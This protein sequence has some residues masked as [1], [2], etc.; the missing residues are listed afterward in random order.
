MTIIKQKSVSSERHAKNVRDYLDGKD[1][2]LRGGW[3][4]F[5]TPDWF[6]RMASTRRTFGHDKPARAGAKNTILYHQVLAFLP[7]ESSCNG[8]P[9]TP[10]KCMLYAEQ[11]ISERYPNHQVVYVLHEE[12]DEQGKRFAV[13]LAIN[14]S[15]VV[16]GKRLDEGRSDRAKRARAAHVRRLDEEWGL[17]QVKKGVP[18][19]KIR[20]Q[21]PRGAEAAML[22]RGVKPYKFNMRKLCQLARD[23][24]ESMEEFLGMLNEWGV[25]VKVENGRLYTADADDPNP[26]KF[27]FNLARLDNSFNADDLASAY[28][29]FDVAVGAVVERQNKEEVDA[30]RAE[31]LLKVLREF[32]AYEKTAE[33]AKG[34]PYDEFPKFK[35]PKQPACIFKDPETQRTVMD[36]IIRTEKLKRAMAANT[37]RRTEL[38]GRP[39]RRSQDAQAQQ[40]RREADRAPER[41][42]ERER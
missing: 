37:P 34:T 11:W 7:E 15:D 4:I 39:G 18:N 28:P 21:K 13:H 17:Q 41:T 27:W 5:Y 22:A 20:V 8:G 33:E 12:S 10:E 29:D 19:S 31:Y 23:N 38:S 14:R 30:A 42:R 1:A 24:A 3:N 36:Y 26:G 9:M 40:P 16:T 35:F 2:L 25:Q 6:S 32:R